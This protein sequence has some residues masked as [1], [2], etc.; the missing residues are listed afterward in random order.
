MDYLAEVAVVLIN[1]VEM[2]VGNQ[3][4]ALPG[5]KLPGHILLGGLAREQSGANGNVVDGGLKDGAA[6]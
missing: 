5:G 4:N 1:L 2:F 6:E 3:L